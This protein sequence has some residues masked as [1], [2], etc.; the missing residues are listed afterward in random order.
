MNSF[1]SSLQHKAQ[2]AW[3]FLC[4][5]G[6]PQLA[7]GA[8]ASSAKHTVPALPPASLA[9]PWQRCSACTLTCELHLCPCGD[10]QLHGIVLWLD[11]ST[12]LSLCSTCS[13]E[14]EAPEQWYL[15]STSPLPHGF[16]ACICSQG[17]T[18]VVHQGSRSCEVLAHP[19]LCLLLSLPSLLAC[20]LEKASNK[21]EISTAS[22]A[23]S[24]PGSI[25]RSAEG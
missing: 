6:C 13:K 5:I 17:L 9:V 18:V 2:L 3:E 12:A 7:P 15:C 23:T 21:G 22:D 19:A 25:T 10:V 20:S 8:P 1:S 24:C 14:L 11:I 4:S 16:L